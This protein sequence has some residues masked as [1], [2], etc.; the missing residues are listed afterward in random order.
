MYPLSPAGRRAYADELDRLVSVLALL[1][2][3]PSPALRP[4]L[5]LA[6][7]LEEHDATTVVTAMLGEG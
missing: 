7:R 4:L 5:S 2:T 6:R 1:I 3:R